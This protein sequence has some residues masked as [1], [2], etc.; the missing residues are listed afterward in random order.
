LEALNDQLPSYDQPFEVREEFRN[1]I[2]RTWLQ[3]LYLPAELNQISQQEIESLEN[4]LYA[5]LLIIQCRKMAIAFPP[6]IWEEIESR[7][8]RTTRS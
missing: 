7:M 1:K 6:K 4:Y 8:L 2:S 5:N 3:T